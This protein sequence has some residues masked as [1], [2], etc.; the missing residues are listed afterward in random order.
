MYLLNIW[1]ILYV[2]YYLLAMLG[3]LLTTVET[4]IGEN[5]SYSAA[6]L[7][8]LGLVFVSLSPSRCLRST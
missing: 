3:T 5:G 2:L 6:S 8:S 4:W 1:V 7:G